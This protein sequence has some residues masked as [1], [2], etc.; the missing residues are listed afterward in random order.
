MLKRDNIEYI[1]AIPPT[2]GQE[3]P[4]LFRSCICL[5]TVLAA[6]LAA[7]E[8]SLPIGRGT[9]GLVQVPFTADN[10]G[11]GMIACSAALAHWYSLDL[12]EAGPGGSVR[13]TLWYDPHDGDVVL[14]NASMDRMPVQALWCGI[15]ERAW[16]TRTSIDLERKAASVPPPVHVACRREGERLS[17]R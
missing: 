7:A 13:A 14:L 16:A 4:R 8:E 12:G 3:M 9:D 11:P 2:D 6:R 15:A 1:K 17:C 5:L 10:S